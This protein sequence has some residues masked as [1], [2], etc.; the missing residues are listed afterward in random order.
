MLT[1]PN[2]TLNEL[3]AELKTGRDLTPA[4]VGTA[5]ACMISE[6]VADGDKVEFLRA[7]A[8]KGESPS[9][10]A[11]FAAYFRSCA[12]D[13]GVEEWADR[14]IDV[15]GTGGDHSG[16]FNV[17]TAVAF[18]AATAG[19]P[20][21]KHGNRSITSRCGSAQLLEALGVPLQGDD[22]MWRRCLRQHNFAFFFAPEYHPAFRAV[23]PARRR[24]AEEKVR[25]IFNL[26]GPLIN[27]GQ[28]KHQM[29]GVFAAEWVRPVA[30]ALGTLGLRRGFVVHSRL[31][32]GGS[33]DE[34]SCCGANTAVGFGEFE[35]RNESF[36]PG[37][38]GLAECTADD[39]IGGD[40]Q[41]NID[42]LEALLAGRANPGLRATVAMNA[43]VAL[44]AAGVES[45]PKEGVA[46]AL[47]LLDSGRVAA[48]LD[49]LLQFFNN[50]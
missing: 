41:H 37:D 35:G 49:G 40:V 3:T 32:G 14:A 25:T 19:V 31:E 17:S 50:R 11:A 21:F 48:W 36:L 22:I 1:G 20:V 16:S 33:L 38:V 43:G 34:L 7:L 46:R 26:L 27:P 44:W 29:M 4:E 23:M 18:V 10:V 28:P 24:L 45:G 42:L 15:C 5:A 13:P 9:E 39:L 30:E 12:R 6:D 8:A 47:E 2:D